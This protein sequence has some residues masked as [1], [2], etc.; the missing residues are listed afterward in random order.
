MNVIFWITANSLNQ[1]SKWTGMTYNE[2]NIIVYYLVI[3]LTW[4]IMLDIIIGLPLF[5]PLLIL[6]WMYII[7]K[8]RTKRV[9]QMWCDWAFQ[10]SVGLLLWFKR[11]GWNYIV[12]SVIN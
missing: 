10:D 4:I 1:I 6:A 2:I 12:S 7:V 3:P 9:F 5:T 11:M 8:T